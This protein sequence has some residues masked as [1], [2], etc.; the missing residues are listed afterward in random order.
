MDNLGGNGSKGTTG[1]AV[2]GSSLWHQA[3]GIQDAYEDLLALAGGSEDGKRLLNMGASDVEWLIKAL[4]VPNLRLRH[5]PGHK[6]AR[7]LATT[8][9]FPGMA[10][11]LA[12][13]NLLKFLAGKGDRVNIVTGAEVVE[14]LK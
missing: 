14:L 1:I 13:V 10:V 7:T 5:T 3:S 2:P 6:C 9:D 4:G 12:A 11:T 8:K